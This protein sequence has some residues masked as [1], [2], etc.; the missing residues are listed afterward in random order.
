MP[1][2]RP[3][4]HPFALIRSL[5]AT[6][7]IDT[8]SPIR[9]PQLSRCRPVRPSL[10]VPARYAQRRPASRRSPLVRLRALNTGICRLR[11]ICLLGD[12]EN[13]P[14]RRDS[15]QA[16]DLERSEGLPDCCHAHFVG[17]REIPYGRELLPWQPF[18]RFDPLPQRGANSPVRRLGAAWRHAADRRRIVIIYAV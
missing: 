14:A 5:P 1:W 2:L 7:R 3:T 12:A 15:D 6:C 8:P 9:W 16:I 11:T 18:P 10:R 13:T 17:R 4:S